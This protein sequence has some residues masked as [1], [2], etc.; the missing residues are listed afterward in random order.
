M[1]HKIIV[2]Y[3]KAEMKQKQKTNYYNK[4]NKWKMVRLSIKHILMFISSTAS[5]KKKKKNI[6]EK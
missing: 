1:P 6:K 2:N 5:K 3:C 4:D